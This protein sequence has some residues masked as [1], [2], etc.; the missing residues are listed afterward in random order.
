MHQPNPK[1]NKYETIL[2]FNDGCVGA[3][4][5]KQHIPLDVEKL[6]KELGLE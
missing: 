5:L 4:E 3:Y 2:T 1:I 6:V